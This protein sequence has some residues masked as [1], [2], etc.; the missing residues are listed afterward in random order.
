MLLPGGRISGGE[1]SCK[2]EAFFF[3][4]AVFLHLTGHCISPPAG[5]VTMKKIMLFLLAATGA[6]LCLGQSGAAVN[7]K[8]PGTVYAE[9]QNISFHVIDGV[10]LRAKRMEGYMIPRPGKVVSLDDKKSFT[11]QIKNAETYISEGDLSALLN[12]YILPHAQTSIQNVAI[13][14]EGQ[15]MVVKGTLKKGVSI[16]FEGKSTLGITPNGDLH[17]HLWISRQREF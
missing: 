13:H 9:A 17:I 15:T 6:P 8:T 11:L 2:R 3:T 14:F 4:I 10:T 1:L 12:T 5:A 7:A 16:P